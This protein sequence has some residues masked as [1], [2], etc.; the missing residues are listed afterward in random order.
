MPKFKSINKDFDRYFDALFNL[1]EAGEIETS[2]VLN[3]SS[4]GSLWIAFEYIDKGLLGLVEADIRR[5]V[6]SRDFHGPLFENTAMILERLIEVSEGDRVI[7][8]YRAAIDHRLKALKAEGAMRDKTKIVSARNAS[9]KWVRFYMPAA[10]KMMKDYGALLM[11]LDRK[12]PELE[13]L[14]QMANAIELPK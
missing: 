13:N 2:D 11:R 10:K 5:D 7:A 3:L 1:S 9:A 6:T 14:I 4:A 8:I 12:D